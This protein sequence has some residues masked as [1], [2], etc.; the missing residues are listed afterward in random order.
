MVLKEFSWI[1]LLVTSR[2]LIIGGQLHPPVGDITFTNF[3]AF[4]ISTPSYFQK[5]HKQTIKIK[6]TFIIK[7]HEVFSETHG[8]V[9]Y[10]I[11][12]EMATLNKNFAVS[13]LP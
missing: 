1:H 11:T 4:R 12:G 7:M 2:F 13:K 6:K 9:N 8:M 5:S 10:G 3:T